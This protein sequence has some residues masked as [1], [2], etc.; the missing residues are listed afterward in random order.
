MKVIRHGSILNE[1]RKK[2]LTELVTPP[3]VLSV[4]RYRSLGR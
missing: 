1:K 3:S 4:I 2:K